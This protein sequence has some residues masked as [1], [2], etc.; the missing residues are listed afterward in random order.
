MPD[1]DSQSQSNCEA[2]KRYPVDEDDG[3]ENSSAIPTTR[4]E[5]ESTQRA[6]VRGISGRMLVEKKSRIRA[7]ERALRIFWVL[8][9]Y[10]IVGLAMKDDIRLDG[11]GATRLVAR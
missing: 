6:Q 7:I 1:S 9:L 11:A 8:G 5:N 4:L 2:L 3:S 10:K